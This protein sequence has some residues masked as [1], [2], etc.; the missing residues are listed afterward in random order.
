[1]QKGVKLTK[2]FQ[3]MTFFTHQ[4][5]KVFIEKLLTCRSLIYC[6]LDTI[7]LSLSTETHKTDRNG[8]NEQNAHWEKDEVIRRVSKDENKWL[9]HLLFKQILT[10]PF[11]GKNLKSSFLGELKKLNLPPS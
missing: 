6:W 1:M 10:F 5:Y 8:A 2:R 11:N 7:R 9:L 4:V 3:Q